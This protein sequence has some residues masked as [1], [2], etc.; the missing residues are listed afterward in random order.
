MQL[1]ITHR[2]KSGKLLLPLRFHENACVVLLGIN[3]QNCL[4]QLL[5]MKSSTFCF[6]WSE[7]LPVPG[8]EPHGASW[9]ENVVQWRISSVLR[10]EIPR[11]F[12]YWTLHKTEWFLSSLIIIIKTSVKSRSFIKV[13]TGF[14]SGTEEV[15]LNACDC[16]TLAVSKMTPYSLNQHHIVS[17]QITV[18]DMWQ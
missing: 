8:L 15:S 7:S 13:K 14:K 9:Y 11:S 4:S 6:R 10:F 3:C 1:V 2:R 18:W 16:H 5:V 17:L 12:C